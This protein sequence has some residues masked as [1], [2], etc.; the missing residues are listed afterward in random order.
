MSKHKNLKKSVH[1]RPDFGMECEI[2]QGIL[3]I[4]EEL[5]KFGFDL[6]EQQVQKFEIHSLRLRQYSQIMNL[7]KHVE[8]DTIIHRHFLDSLIALKHINLKVDENSKVVDI[9]TGAGFPGFPIAIY[10]NCQLTAIDSLSKR[11]NFL[12]DVVD[13]AGITNIELLHL[14]AEQLPKKSDLRENFDYCFF[15]A[16]S[17][18]SKIVEIAHPYIKKGGSII[19]YK[20]KE[21][22]EEISA[23][24]KLLSKYK[25]KIEEDI[26]YFDS[27]GVERRVLVIKK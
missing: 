23:A 7:S 13:T 15:R 3:D 20:S 21:I 1:E 4:K 5:A 26:L 6:S 10:T 14:R 2:G 25:L 8:H 9:G 16:F 27:M 11:I 18:L 24:A 17:D 12:Q 22:D 19:A